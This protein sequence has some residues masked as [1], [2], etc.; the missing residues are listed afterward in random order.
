[1]PYSNSFFFGEGGEESYYMSGGA[2]FLNF[3]TE[4]NFDVY[5]THTLSRYLKDERL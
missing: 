3:T 5:P 4:L 2:V 1:M